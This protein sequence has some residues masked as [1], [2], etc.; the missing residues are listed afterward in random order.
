MKTRVCLVAIVILFSSYSFGQDRT[1][2]VFPQVADGKFADGSSYYSIMSISNLNNMQVSCSINTSVGLP[3]SRFYNTAPIL[4]PF[5]SYL[6]PT[7]GTQAFVSGW[8]TL[9]CT[10]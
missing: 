3:S 2:H 6:N 1:F 7:S 8:A 5:N 9:T 4:P 10:A